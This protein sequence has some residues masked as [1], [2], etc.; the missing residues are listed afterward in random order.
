MSSEIVSRAPPCSSKFHLK[1]GYNVIRIIQGDEWSIAIRTCYRH[2][3]Y[4]VMPFALP[5]GHA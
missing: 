3:E 5:N 4:L 2:F 1:S